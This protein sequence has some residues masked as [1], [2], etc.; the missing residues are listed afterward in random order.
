MGQLSAAEGPALSLSVTAWPRCFLAEG[1]GPHLH[2][3]HKSFTPIPTL[4]PFAF[5]QRVAENKGHEVEGTLEDDFTL[6]KIQCEEDM[7]VKTGCSFTQGG[8]K[9]CH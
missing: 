4:I 2:V 6:E 9:H 7:E 1:W 8:P 5:Q 3:H